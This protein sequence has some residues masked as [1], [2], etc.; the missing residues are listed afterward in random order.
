MRYTEAIGKRLRELLKE[1]NLTQTEFAGMC[2]I[3]R[4]T[5]NGVIRGRNKLVTLETLVVICNTLHISLREFFNADI[6]E[7]IFEHVEKPKGR[8]I[9]IL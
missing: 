8:K 2:S 3:S 9:P 6:F 7:K 4:M 5:I 1:K